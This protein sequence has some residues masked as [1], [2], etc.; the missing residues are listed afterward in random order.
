M[1]VG[2]NVWQVFYDSVVVAYVQYYVLVEVVVFYWCGIQY[3]FDIFVVDFVIV[4]K[5]EV[6]IICCCNRQGDYL[7]EV[8]YVVVCCV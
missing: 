2:D 5:V 7:I 4:G 8:K 1:F 6:V 3:Q